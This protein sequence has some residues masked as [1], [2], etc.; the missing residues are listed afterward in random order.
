MFGEITGVVV[1]VGRK[2]EDAAGDAASSPLTS[3]SSSSSKRESSAEF[4][5]S[6]PVGACESA[7][8]R[9]WYISS[10]IIEPSGWILVDIITSV[11]HHIYD[12]DEEANSANIS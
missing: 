9:S 3:S 8:I 12:V 4:E 7:I 10:I 1:D 2:R 11:S 5:G 6:Q